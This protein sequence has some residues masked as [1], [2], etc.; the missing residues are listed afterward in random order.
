M[1]DGSLNV[2]EATYILGDVD[3]NGIV[4][5]SDAMLALFAATNK[6]TLTEPQM[7]AANVISADGLNTADAI[8]IL[9]YATKKISSF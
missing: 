1:T 3:G 8:R 9:Y 6:I 5:T 2:I 4:Q 7:L